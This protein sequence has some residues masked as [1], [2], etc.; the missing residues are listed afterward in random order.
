MLSTQSEL[1]VARDEGFAVVEEFIV[2]MSKID[3]SES[4]EDRN[5]RALEIGRSLKM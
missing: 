3:L 5:A 2:G 1:R 4:T